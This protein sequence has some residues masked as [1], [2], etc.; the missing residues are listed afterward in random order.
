VLLYRRAQQ[1]QEPGSA[2]VQAARGAASLK[3]KRLEV[4]YPLAGLEEPLRT[5]SRGYDWAAT[6]QGDPS[7]EAFITHLRALSRSVDATVARSYARGIP[8][9]WWER[10]RLDR[11]VKAVRAAWQTRFGRQPPDATDDAV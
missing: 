6:Y 1:G 10:R 3:L 2:G 5:L 9:S 4:K 8:P 11:Q 7:G